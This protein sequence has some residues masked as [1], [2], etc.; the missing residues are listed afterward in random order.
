MLNLRQS[1]TELVHDWEENNN[2][3]VLYNLSLK[4]NEYVNL[5]HSQLHAL[6]TAQLLSADL[7]TKF[8]TLDSRRGL[9]ALG[10]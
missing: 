4:I 7:L 9:R 1:D 3:S 10:L 2:N 5:I 6:V 8:T